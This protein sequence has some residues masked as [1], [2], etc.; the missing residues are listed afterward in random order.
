MTP[1]NINTWISQN[2]N[3]LRQK[4]NAYN[5][6][7]EDAFQDAYITLVQNFKMPASSKTFETAFF[8]A[9]RDITHKAINE[10]YIVNHPSELFFTLLP[11]N[12]E[13]E[14]PAKQADIN[15]LFD[16]SNRHS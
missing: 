12:D 2:A 8:K 1:M 4:I 3:R 7:D 14:L 16:E 9:Y 10:S 6:L 11:S 13:D 15:K 5:S